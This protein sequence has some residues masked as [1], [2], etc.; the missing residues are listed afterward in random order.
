MRTQAGFVAA[1]PTE[2]G[3]WAQAQ[4]QSQGRETYGV[5]VQMLKSAPTSTP[6]PPSNDQSGAR[7]SG[8]MWTDRFI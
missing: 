4:G 6:C 2:E 7:G 3:P 5:E 8:R 1:D